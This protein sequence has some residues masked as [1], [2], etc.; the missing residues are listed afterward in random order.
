MALGTERRLVTFVSEAEF[1]PCGLEQP[2]IA[3]IY[4]NST[5]ITTGKFKIRVDGIETP[6]ITYS[7][8]FAT[9][10]ARIT[11]AL[12]STFSG[13]FTVTSSNPF[14]RITTA[15]NDFIRVEIVPVDLGKPTTYNLNINGTPTGNFKMSVNGIET[16]NISLSGSAPTSSDV[17][18]ALN[19]LSSVPGTE[20]IVTGSV[21]DGFVIKGS[22]AIRWVFGI[23]HVS[24]ATLSINGVYT[25]NGLLTSEITTS[26]ADVI[27]PQQG[28]KRISLT[29][30]L[31]S[32]K[33]G[34]KIKTTETAGLGELE[35]YPIHVGSSG[36]F[37]LSMYG[38]VVGKWLIPMSTEG[39]SGTLY[40]YPQGK[41][42]GKTYSA[43]RAI[44]DGFDE[45]LPFHEKIEVTIT[46]TRQGALVAPRGTLITADN[47]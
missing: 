36:T 6:D 10:A 28:S 8:T 30:D 14:V 42:I 26:D 23:N 15:T 9:L 4:I 13:V 7:S 21:D 17:A 32:M 27:V 22:K 41:A 18:S 20:F 16:S 24:T 5:N 29:A 1:L 25:D 31:M 34:Q 2:H 35:D 33:F 40:W 11:S 38:T 44:L 37:S 12:S 45:D 43:M 3:D 19:G 39:L 47:I 46:G